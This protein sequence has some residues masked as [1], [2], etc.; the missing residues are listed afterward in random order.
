MNLMR[1][2]REY[3]VG[4]GSVAMWWFGQSGYIFKSPEGTLASVDLY[5]TDSVGETVTNIDLHRKFPPPIQPEEVDVDYFLCTHNHQDHTDPETIR[6]LRNKD[7][8]RFIG[9]MP[10]CGVYRQS[11]I[12]D[13]R[14]T[15]AWPACSAEYSD[16]R[17]TGA[18]AL[19]TDDTDLNHMGYVLRFGSGPVIYITGD[20][21]YHELLLSAKKHKP[22]LLITCINGGYNNL[23]HWEASKLA[24]GISPRAAIPCHYD[25]F[26]D[27]SADPKLFRAAL[28]VNAPDVRYQ[29]L[30]HGKPFVFSHF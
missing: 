8:A 20:T 6:R 28:A 10:S 22:D 3:P 9:P 17:I 1:Q 14:I 23:S 16:L 24:A 30:E 19:P 29:E 15:P 13:G 7:T 2:I 4:K 27:N 26:P 25:L 11:G 21:D 12:E 5:L 18:F